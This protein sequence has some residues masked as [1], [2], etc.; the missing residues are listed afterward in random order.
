MFAE[1]EFL[2]VFAISPS[3]TFGHPC[4]GG[5][6]FTTPL[7]KVEGVRGIV[8]SIKRCW[9]LFNKAHRNTVEI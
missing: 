9:D 6:Q 1:F 7:I 8:E 2:P 4:K 3:H 5:V